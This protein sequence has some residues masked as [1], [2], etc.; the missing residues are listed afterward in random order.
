MADGDA[1]SRAGDL[2]PDAHKMKRQT[3]FDST[4]ADEP[5]QVDEV[6]EGPLPHPAVM[7]GWEELYPG[8]SRQLFE[9]MKAESEHRRKMESEFLATQERLFNKANKRSWGGLASGWSIAVAFLIAS[10]VLIL[11]GHAVAGT[12]LGTVDLVALVALFITGKRSSS[13]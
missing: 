12:I 3:T 13:R 10:V 2:P 5:V 8:A 9:E 6:F 4:E 1:I 11:N 7:R